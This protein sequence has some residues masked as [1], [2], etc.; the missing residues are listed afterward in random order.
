MDTEGI[1]VQVLSSL[2]PLLYCELD[3]ES[4]LWF[5]QRQNEGIS[6]VLRDYPDRFLG[7]ATIPLQ[8]PDIALTGQ[9]Y[10]QARA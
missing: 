5:S 3:P 8:K 7:L 10:Q 1:D 2:P 4:C 6:Q 9:G